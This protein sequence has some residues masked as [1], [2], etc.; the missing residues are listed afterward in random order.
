[1]PWLMLTA[2]GRIERACYRPE[3]ACS[4]GIAPGGG[5]RET[6]SGVR[7]SLIAVPGVC[8]PRREMGVLARG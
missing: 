7:G 3:E 4:P 6:I 1:M 8:S 2:G 5:G